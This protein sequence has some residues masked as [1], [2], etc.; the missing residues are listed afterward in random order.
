MK[1][2]DRGV[3]ASSRSVSEASPLRSSLEMTR[4]GRVFGCRHHP[5]TAAQRQPTATAGQA[6][7]FC[8]ASQLRVTN[9]MSLRGA[10]IADARAK[11]AL[12][13]K[14]SP[15]QAICGLRRGKEKS[16]QAGRQQ[17]LYLISSA[18]KKFQAAR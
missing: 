17:K 4:E 10:R 15:W 13:T 9:F 16:R 5:S 18:E 11:R 12:A 1:S 3:Q 7:A 8:G 2:I 14:Q 6:T